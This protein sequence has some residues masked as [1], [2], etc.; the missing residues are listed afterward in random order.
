VNTREIGDKLEKKVIEDLNT[1]K[2]KQ[3]NLGFR[4]TANSGAKWS[5]GDIVHQDYVVEC[6]VKSAKKGFSAPASELNKLI[7]VADKTFKDWIYVQEIHNGRKMVLMDYEA[8][9][10]ITEEH[11]K[12]YLKE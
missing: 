2:G 11:R 1:V 12:R 3:E 6:K 8:F 10:E 7:E 9:I 4:P 5:D